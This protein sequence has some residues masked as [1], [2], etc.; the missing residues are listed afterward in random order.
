M[1]PVMPSTFRIHPALGVAR[2][3]DS[4]G[5]GFLGPELPGVPAN[6]N[7]HTA[8]FDK[9]KDDQGRVKRQGV[10]FRIYEFDE[11]GSVRGEVLPGKRNV[12]A[13]EWTVHVAN[14]KAAFFKFDGSKGEDGDYSKNGLRNAKVAADRGRLEITPAPRTISGCSAPP[15]VLANPNAWTN[16]QIADL[17]EI[18][19]DPEGRLI[20]FGGHGKTYQ[21]P[22]AREIDN[23]VNND[24][25]FDDVSDGPV[26]A[27]IIFANGARVPV[28]G[29]WV[30]VGPPDFAPAI[31]NVVSLYDTLWDLTVRTPE[32][33]IP[34]LAPYRAGERLEAL[35]CQRHDWD[36]KT[37][38][39]QT[40]RPSFVHDIA[41]LLQRALNA[42]FVHAP[43]DAPA[44]HNT[45]GPQVWAELGDP[46]PVHDAL[47]AAIFDRIRDP[48]AEPPADST[49]M[50]RGLG[51]QYCDE[52]KFA[53][54]TPQ[55]ANPR[56]FFS[57]TRVQYALLAQWTSG[58]FVADGTG[59]SPI[60]ASAPPI[61]PD[62]L[63]RAAL[64]NCVGGPFFPG[65]EVSWTV[66]NP[67]IY[68]EPFRV[69]AGVS[70]AERVTTE[71]GF[72]TQSMAVP[73]QADFRECKREELTNPATG[74]PTHAMW[75]AGQRPDDV[76]P[77]NDPDHQVPWA[78]PPHFVASDEE[79]ARFQEMVK[80]WATLGFVARRSKDARK[81]LETERES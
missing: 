80:G 16:V 12:T 46:D 51:D 6:W 75:W 37:R 72:F 73:W 40:F 50:P 14:R 15:V 36:P 27:V 9:F 35:E 5:P 25:W 58:N 52:E 13:I 7:F 62:G 39:F 32:I 21:Q 31:G 59:P 60:P 67:K 61:T 28:I 77:E 8:S 53:A 22:D 29:A 55:R 19:T 48:D 69:K 38:R 49:Q 56:R 44:F 4:P 23:Y 20:F 68:G 64:E 74:E 79:Q 34:A 45:L 2:V 18:R 41:S 78:R 3:G 54:G 66:R 65:I 76:Y 57:L 10:R 11:H 42:V 1:P 43:L 71:P 24:G 30:C 26:T 33:P 81:W 47:R 70:L 17:G 63:D